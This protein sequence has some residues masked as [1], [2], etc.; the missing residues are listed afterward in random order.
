M[1]APKSEREA[2]ER[3]RDELLA[4][5]ESLQ[6]DLDTAPGDTLDYREQLQSQLKRAEKRLAD[7]GE[8]LTILLRDD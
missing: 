1:P 5:V 4:L 7:L 2:L 8:R 6:V 3:E